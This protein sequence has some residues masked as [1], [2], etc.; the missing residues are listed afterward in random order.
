[1]ASAFK[2]MPPPYIADLRSRAAISEELS[3]SAVQTRARCEANNRQEALRVA[4]AAAVKSAVN[5][6]AAM[7]LITRLVA[8]EDGRDTAMGLLGPILDYLYGQKG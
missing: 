8:E 4:D 6:H 5:L 3:Q 2:A 7:N 1:M